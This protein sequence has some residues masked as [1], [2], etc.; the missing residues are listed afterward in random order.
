MSTFEDILE[1]VAEDDIGILGGQA[2]SFTPSGGA[3][4]T[5]TVLVDYID[6]AGHIL[7]DS[8]SKNPT[9]QITALNSS[10]SGIDLSSWNQNDSVFVPP[11]KGATATKHH[12]AEVIQQIS[13]HAVY[14]IN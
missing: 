12:L 10:T 7:D 13:G 2:V 14:R 3:A 6:D 8:W 9:I 11:R 1:T 4:R 5:I